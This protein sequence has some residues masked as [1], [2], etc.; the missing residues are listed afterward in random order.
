MADPDPENPTHRTLVE[1]AAAQLECPMCGHVGFTVSWKLVAKPLGT[2]SLAGHQ[3]K[4]SAREV[5]VVKCDGCGL[6]GAP[7]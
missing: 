4:V 7:D 1:K 5:P 6:E 2:F 3:M